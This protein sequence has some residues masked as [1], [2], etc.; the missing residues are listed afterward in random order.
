MA[1][2]TI[3]GVA[4]IAAAKRLRLNFI[5]MKF[6]AANFIAAALLSAALS[7]IP[8]PAAYATD[9]DAAAADDLKRLMARR[10]TPLRPIPTSDTRP[11][12]AP[13][14]GPAWSDPDSINWVDATVAAG[15]SAAVIPGADANRFLARIAER[16]AGDQIATRFA[17]HAPGTNRLLD[18]LRNERRSSRSW[19]APANT[20]PTEMGGP[21]ATVAE[22]HAWPLPAQLVAELEQLAARARGTAADVDAWSVATLDDLDGVLHTAGPH[23]AAAPA[24]LLGLGDAVEAGM[25][26]A[27]SLADLPLAAETRRA[28]LSLARRVAVWR[29]A[30][31]MCGEVDA[32]SPGGAGSDAGRLLAALEGFEAA[33]LPGQAALVHTSLAS[34]SATPTVTAPAV[35]RAVGDHYFAANVR[36]AVHEGFVSRLLPESS[37]TTG[38]MQDVILGRRVRGTRT[39]EQSTN[40]RFVP[41][42]DRIH[43]ELLVNGD[44]ASRTVT[45]SGPVTIHSRGAA[46]F[47]VRKP[48]MFS[49][50]GLA[51]GTAL[52]SASNQSRLANIQTGFDAVPIMG[53]L[54]RNIAR[55]QHDESRSDV[56][57]EVN[58]KIIVNARREVDA[59]VE[60]RFTEMAATMRGRFWDPL[61]R[62]GLDPT[63]V[64]LETSASVAAA[65]LRLAGPGQLGAHT[66][67]PRPPAAALLTVQLHESS[68]NNASERL[69]IAGRRLGLEDLV[70][71]V[72]ERLGVDARQPDDLPEGVAVT[73][74]AEQPVRVECRDGLVRVRVALDSLESSR[75]SWYDIV[76]QVAYRPVLQGPQVLL[77]RE[78]PVQ[79]SGPGHQGRMEL[80]LRTIFGKIFVKERMIPVLPEKLATHP[81]LADVQAVQ[82]VC[83]DGWLS[84]ALAESAPVATAPPAI[85]VAEQPARRLLRR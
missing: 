6:I 78:G 62:L 57:R 46:T 72:C 56:S 65:R 4:I 49:A 39:V 22:P 53:Q 2:H 5:T 45:E 41:D 38:P 26:L 55:N 80:A 64:K 81:G 50:A 59:Q 40:V 43:M 67:R 20:T 9:S 24:V 23:D 42:D 21:A 33:Q 44:V 83:A 82:A 17:P 8:T 79:L 51:F 77:E 29:A 30:A 58:E 19:D 60:P 61:V 16:R 70:Q 37:V 27:G 75:R 76:A 13:L 10:Q 66:P 7:G 34:I 15:V 25:A 47:I 18:R 52:A 36:I 84:L 1:E 28:A 73:F 68:F 11:G 74:A 32:L 69:G 85:P 31:A 71:I 14:P 35:T 54:V 3:S 12:L 48:I 63:P